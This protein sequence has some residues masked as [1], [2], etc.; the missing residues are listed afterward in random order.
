MSREQ[1]VDPSTGS[2]TTVIVA[3]ARSCTPDSSLTIRTPARSQHPARPRRRRRGRAR[4][5]RHGR[6]GPAARPRRSRATTRRTA[7]AASTNSSS[8]AS[9]AV[10][11]IGHDL[12]DR[13]VV[14][15]AGDRV[16]P[17]R[18]EQRVRLRE[19]RLH[20]ARAGSARRAP[21]RAS[22]RTASA[23]APA[24]PSRTPSAVA[25]VGGEEQR[26]AARAGQRVDVAPH[27]RV[28]L[29]A[30]P[31]RQHEPALG[32]IVACR[33]RRPRTGRGRRASGR[34]RPRT[35]ARRR[36]G[37]RRRCVRRCSMPGVRG[38]DARDLGSDRVAPTR[39]RTRRPGRAAPAGRCRR[40]SATRCAPRRRAARGSPGLNATRRSVV[41]DVPP[42]TCS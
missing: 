3:P 37:S 10:M 42:P 39:S 34:R 38:H 16:A 29:L 18:R 15:H 1:F 31:G 4:T 9:G 30:P 7:A 33:A 35:G 28:E 2:S 14:G 27:H 22:R 36:P 41:V 5:A 19:E 24:S 23:R 26:V 25:S 17:C 8:S 21:G 11:R 13:V 40:R 32:H 6:C 20:V 12:D